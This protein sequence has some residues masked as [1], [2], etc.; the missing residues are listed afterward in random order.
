MAYSPFEPTGQVIYL[1]GAERYLIELAALIRERHYEVEIYQ[2]AQG[3]W[4]WYFYDIPVY[5]LDTGGR[6]EAMNLS[7]GP[8]RLASVLLRYPRLRPRHGRSE[9]GHERSL[10][11]PGPSA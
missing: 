2:S 4:L 1:G 6:K 11:P 9:G 3:D 5:G 7:V 10:S 8:G